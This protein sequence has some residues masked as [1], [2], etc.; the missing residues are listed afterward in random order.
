MGHYSTVYIG[1]KIISV[2][3]HGSHICSE[4]AINIP[5]NYLETKNFG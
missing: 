3:T 5:L 2:Q 1:Y 4:V